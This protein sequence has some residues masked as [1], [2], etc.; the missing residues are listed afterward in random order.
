MARVRIKVVLDPWVMPYLRLMVRLGLG[1]KGGEAV[2]EFIKEN[3]MRPA[4]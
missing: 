1:R 2:R 4:K 3:G